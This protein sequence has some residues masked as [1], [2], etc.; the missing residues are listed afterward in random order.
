MRHWIGLTLLAVCWTLVGAHSSFAQQ[1]DS[2][3][4]RRLTLALHSA[5]RIRLI[6]AR[7]QHIMKLE[8]ADQ[9]ADLPE[10]LDLLKSGPE[11]RAEP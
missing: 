9:P 8:V 2:E 7:M 10:R 3:S 6:V 5:E 11:G 4:R 1:D